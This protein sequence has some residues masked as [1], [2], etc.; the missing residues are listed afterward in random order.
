GTTFPVLPAS[1][2]RYQHDHPEIE[3]MS[4]TE[5]ATKL[6]VSRLIYV[7]IEDFATRSDDSVALFRG[8]AKATVKVIEVSGDQAKVAFELNNV[9]TAFPPKAPKEGIPNAGDAKIYSGLIDSFATEIVHVF[10][11]YQVEE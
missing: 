5:V 11:A 4:V 10:V 3:A 1:I 2:V 7:E 9:E 8:R 6:G